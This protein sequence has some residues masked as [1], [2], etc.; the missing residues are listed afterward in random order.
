MGKEQIADRMISMA[1]GIPMKQI[2][3]GD[4]QDDDFIKI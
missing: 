3:T 2:A 4:L 1:S